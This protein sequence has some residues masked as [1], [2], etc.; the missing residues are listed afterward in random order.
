[1][2]FQNLGIKA[3]IHP[4]EKNHFG[5]TKGKLQKT[6]FVDEGKISLPGRWELFMVNQIKLRW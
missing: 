4:N 3:G 6:V 5:W 2:H 1:M